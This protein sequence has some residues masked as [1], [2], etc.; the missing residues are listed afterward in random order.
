MSKG[1]KEGYE[2]GYAKPPKSG[3]FKPGTSGNP[4]GRPKGAKNFKTLLNRALS[5]QVEVN[6]GGRRKRVSKREL[7]AIAFVNRAIKG[8]DRATTEIAKFDL[9]FSAEREASAARIAEAP[10]E[11]ESAILDDLLQRAGLAKPKKRAA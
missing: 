7:M 9:L 3:Q 1:S 4:K 11:T 6:E 5:E 8:S 10:S 2:V